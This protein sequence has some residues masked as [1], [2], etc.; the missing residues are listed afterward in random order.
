MNKTTL[1]IT[2]QP[3]KSARPNP[4]VQFFDIEQLLHTIDDNNLDVKAKANYNKSDNEED[5]ILQAKGED[6]NSP[7]PPIVP[8]PSLPLDD[9]D[10]INTAAV[11]LAELLAD[12]PINKKPKPITHTLKASHNNNNNNN[13]KE[14]EGDY[15]LKAWV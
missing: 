7:L 13:N 12:R 10:N 15:Q 6:L 8:S 1:T 14:M 4:V 11:E 3:H 2:P 5:I 9:N